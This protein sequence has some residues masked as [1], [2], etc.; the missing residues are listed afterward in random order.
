[1]KPLRFQHK[2]GGLTLFGQAVSVAA[3]LLIG[4]VSYLTA[5]PQAHEF[6]HHDAG[7]E[8]HQCVVTSFAA[9]E[10]LFLAPQIELRP[11]AV[12]VEW[13]HFASTEVLRDKVA[14]LLPPVCG[15]PARSLIA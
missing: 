14:N 1:M 3:V 8:E 13:V 5:S 12:V 6:F 4:L 9:G 15:P 11:T 2:K 7:H 10:G